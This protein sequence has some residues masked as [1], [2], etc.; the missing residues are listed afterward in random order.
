MAAQS[1]FTPSSMHPGQSK[2][3]HRVS[4]IKTGVIEVV[5]NWMEEPPEDPVLCIIDELGKAY[6]RGYDAGLHFSMLACQRGL[7]SILH[8]S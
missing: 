6:W 4:L 8:H 5:M 3:R 7:F 1:Y 2:N